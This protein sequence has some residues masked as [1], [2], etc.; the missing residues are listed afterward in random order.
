MFG[1]TPRLA[2]DPTRWHAQNVMS[3]ELPKKNQ[4][5]NMSYVP[6]T[7]QVMCTA[8]SHVL[9]MFWMRY[10]KLILNKYHR[11]ERLRLRGS[12]ILRAGHCESTTKMSY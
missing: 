1:S 10:Y 8:V 4:N 12:G 11:R 6:H 7:A 2:L 5:I 3:T 9:R